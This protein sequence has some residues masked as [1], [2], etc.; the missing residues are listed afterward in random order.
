MLMHV[1]VV[2]EPFQQTRPDC[3]GSRVR[4]VVERFDVF[5]G[6]RPRARRVE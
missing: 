3:H 1:V 6:R 4:R 5:Q 2:A